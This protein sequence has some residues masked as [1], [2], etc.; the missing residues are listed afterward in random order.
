MTCPHCGGKVSAFWDGRTT[1]YCA[2]CGPV[3]KKGKKSKM[4]KEAWE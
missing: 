1:Y 2:H 3:D 4:M